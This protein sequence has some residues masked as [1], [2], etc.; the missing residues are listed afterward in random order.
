MIRAQFCRCSAV[1]LR[2][3]LSVLRVTG[4]C[5]R[6]NE[7][8]FMPCDGANIL[9]QPR[10]KHSDVHTS[11]LKRCYSGQALINAA[12]SRLQP[13]MKL[14]RLDRPIGRPNIFAY[15]LC[16]NNFWIAEITLNVRRP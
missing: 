5:G 13:Y 7:F 1:I 10:I 9:R 15:F 14:M 3:P 2:Q 16:G 8:S 4:I 12:P 6:A 11:E